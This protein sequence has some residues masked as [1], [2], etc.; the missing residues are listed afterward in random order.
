[1]PP[2]P[3]RKCNVG[4]TSVPR[5]YCVGGSLRPSRNA[6]QMGAIQHRGQNRVIHDI[7][8]VSDH[9]QPNHPRNRT[10]AGHL[11][12]N[13]QKRINAR[14]DLSVVQNMQPPR[15]LVRIHTIGRRINGVKIVK[16]K[17]NI[18]R[19][20]IARIMADLRVTDRTIGVVEYPCG[21][22]LLIQH[23]INSGCEIFKR[24]HTL[25]KYVF[26]SS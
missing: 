26:D 10:I 25:F 23:V 17:A 7:G 8:R 1:M 3:K 22:C 21:Q 5:R 18:P 9:R 20:G 2:N 11:P 4:I 15:R 19:G 6:P 13:D 14:H 24:L 16:P 12:P